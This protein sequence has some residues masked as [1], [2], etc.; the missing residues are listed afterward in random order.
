MG[1]EG[2]DWFLKFIEET[3]PKYKLPYES[4]T[5]EDFDIP[6]GAVVL[7]NPSFC[8]GDKFCFSKV[9]CIVVDKEKYDGGWKGYEVCEYI[10]KWDSDKEVFSE[11][12][13]NTSIK[14]FDEVSTH[15]MAFS[16]LFQS[17]G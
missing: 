4:L 3:D 7:Q 10:K 16:S 11:T 2:H 13:L 5:L 14:I 15:I 17:T 12:K 9:V 8:V 1:R 6:K